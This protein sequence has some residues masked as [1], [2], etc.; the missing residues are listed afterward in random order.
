MKRRDFIK[1][2]STGLAVVAVGTMAEWPAFWGAGQAHAATLPG[3]GVVRLEMAEIQA[4]MVDL[5]AVPMWS[6]R[7]TT[8]DRDRDEAHIAANPYDSPYIPRIPGLTL[9]ALAGDRVRLRIANDINRGG[10]IK[11][12]AIPGVPLTVDGEQVQQVSI[13]RGEDDVEIEFTAPAPGTYVYLDPTNAPVNRMMGLHGVLVVLPHPVGANGSP[14]DAP[15]QNVRQLFEDLGRAPHFPGHPWNG[16]RNA[17]WVTNTIDPDKCEQVAETSGT[18]SSQQFLSGILPQ[19]FTLNGKSGFFAAQHGQSLFP[20]LNPGGLR[21]QRHDVEHLN[22]AAIEKGIFDTQ[23][24]VA[25]HGNVGQPAVIRCV[26]AGLMWHSLHIHG[27]HLYPLSHA[28]YLNG[29]RMISNNL[30]MLD[31]WTLAPGDIKDMLIPFIQPPDIPPAK[32]PPQQEFF[33][34]LYPM[35]DHNEIS[36]TAAGGNYPHGLSTHWEISGPMDP[37]NLVIFVDRADLRVRTGRFELKGRLS[38]VPQSGLTVDIHAGGADGE[39]LLEGLPVDS[40]G[41]WECRGRALKAFSGGG[42]VTAVYHRPDENGD[43]SHARVSRTV[44]LRAR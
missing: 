25:I 5:R 30:T 37:H 44:P 17:V 16:E 18:V 15:T 39:I 41:R 24:N 35:H 38:S 36:N 43:Q 7:L 8:G 42:F 34:L 23:S 21:D 20:T 3:R 28:N 12:F 6:F 4:E 29:S 33:P 10:D 1:F 32:W 9:V 40:Q 27:N 22:W 26:N 13:E 19:Y 2:T 11:R 14:Y 31:A